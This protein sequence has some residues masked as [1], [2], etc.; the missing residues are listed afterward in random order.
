M[1]PLE[2]TA[3]LKKLAKRKKRNKSHRAQKS[4]HILYPDSPTINI[5]SC[6]LLGQCTCMLTSFLHLHEYINN[7]SEPFLGTYIY[8]GPLPLDI[9][10]YFFK[11]RDSPWNTQ[12]SFINLYQHTFIQSVVHIPILSIDSMMSFILPNVE[13]N[14]SS[15]ITLNHQISLTLFN[16]EHFPYPAKLSTDETSDCGGAGTLQVSGGTWSCSTFLSYG[17]RD[18]GTQGLPFC[19]IRSWKRLNKATKW[20]MCNRT[21]GY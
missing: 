17:L 20:Q 13:S 10:V 5:L 19:W 3:T 9:S 8:Y 15:D 21:T 2:I 11:R 1:K 7:Y 12:N 16:L 4:T 14:L 6:F 18:P